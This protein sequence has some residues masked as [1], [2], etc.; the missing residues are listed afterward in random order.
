MTITEAKKKLAAAGVGSPD[1]DALVL[2]EI[3]SG[4]NRE[5][6]LALADEDVDGNYEELVARR[7]KRVPLAQIS[8]KKEFY[9][10]DMIVNADVLQPRPESEKIVDFA[11][12]YAPKDSSLI[13]V[14][15]GCG[16]IAIAIAKHRPDLKITATEVSQDALAVAKANITAHQTPIT[17][18]QSNLFSALS[19]TNLKK[20]GSFSDGENTFQTVVANLPYLKDEEE[21]MPEVK[22]EPAVALHGGPDGLGLYRK[23][24][25]QLP[26]Y[27]AK[28]GYV[29]IESDPWQ[30]PE[31][32][33]IAGKA[34][35]KPIEQDY[36]I[37]GFRLG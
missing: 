3:A 36:F 10:L 4:K 11:I 26:A 19:S 7:A 9:G 12:K 8:G 32:I 18:L 17:L 2:A 25:D 23:F 1:L 35:L 5:Y 34:G 33:K 28:P 27:L 22:N 6:W 29:F 30:Q 31:L 14:G 16:A 15:T 37:L 13:D 24:F 21:L 20:I